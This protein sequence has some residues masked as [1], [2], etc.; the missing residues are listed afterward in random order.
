MSTA[1]RRTQ[2]NNS[3]LSSVLVQML[4]QLIVIVLSGFFSKQEKQSDYVTVIPKKPRALKSTSKLLTVDEV[5]PAPTVMCQGSTMLAYTSNETIQYIVDNFG[6]AIVACASVDDI[7]F[8]SLAT[9]TACRKLSPIKVPT[10][11]S[12]TSIARETARWLKTSI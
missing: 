6:D 7:S 9:R 4:F 12:G 10:K 5:R 3:D 11:V 8:S 2:S 1:K